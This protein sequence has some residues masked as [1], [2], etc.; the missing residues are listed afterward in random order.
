MLA[1][2]KPS[3]LPSLLPFPRVGAVYQRFTSVE[4]GVV[5]N[6]IQSGDGLVVNS[7]SGV[8]FTVN[9]QY[10]PAGPRTINLVFKS[11]Q[12]GDVKITNQFEALLAPSILPRT[13]LTQKLLLGAKEVR[14]HLI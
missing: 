4:E 8:T 10:A 6:I 14:T 12:I 9:A 2:D 1:G 7:G 5:Q 11:A 13:T 3:W